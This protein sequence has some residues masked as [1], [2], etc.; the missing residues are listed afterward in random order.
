MMALSREP[1]RATAFRDLALVVLTLVVVKQALLPVSQLY[2]GPAST[3][4]AMVIAT[5]LLHR[6]GSGWYDLGLRWPASWLATVGLTLLTM[7]LF[8]A[9]TQAMGLLAD[10]F[11]A[12]LNY[13]SRFDHVEGNL[14]AYLAIMVL[15]W[16]HGSF[17]EELLFRAFIMTKLAVGLGQGRWA[18]AVALLLSSVFFGYRHA[19][20]QGIHGALLAGAG[21]FAFGLMYIWFGRRNVLPII[22]AHGL[23]NT[24]GQTFRFLGIED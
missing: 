19:Y 11:F 3:L 24:L 9:A 17:F 8:I 15:V 7:A 1:F 18:W 14:V 10:R 5:W 23:F 4:S 22:L 21:G 6:R 20:Y 12:D 16:T 13:G 2:A